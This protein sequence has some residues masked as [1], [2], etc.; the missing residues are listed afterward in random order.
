MKNKIIFPIIIFLLFFKIEQS[1]SQANAGIDQE[2]CTNHTFLN[3]NIPASGYTGTWSIISGGCSFANEHSSST[4]VTN[5]L[6]NTTELKWTVTDGTNT[7]SDNVLIINNTATN[8]VV[9][10]DDEICNNYYTLNANIFDSGESGLWSVVAGTG[11]FANNANNVTDV[12]GLS[13][14][15]NKF[16]WRITKGICHSEDTITI[17]N[18]K[19]T[20]TCEADKTI[21]EDFT[22]ISANNPTYGSGT[23]SVI[24][25]SG[26]PTISNINVNN[27]SVTNLGADTNNLKWTVVNGSCSA[28]DNLIIT[29]DKPTTAIAG[30][31]KT[32][33]T[34]STNLSANN[35]TQGTGTW[36]VVSGNGTF[37][38]PN[39]Y[40]TQVNLINVGLNIYKWKIVKNLCSSED[41]VEI[42]FDY[43]EADAGADDET[44]LNTY[45]LSAN[46]LSG[47]TG[48]WRVTGGSGTF[49]NANQNN[50]E[51][52]NIGN[53]ANTYEWELTRGT[54]VHTDYVTIT[55]NTP[56]TAIAGEDKETCNGTTTL[57]ASLPAIGTGS[58]SLI[59][60]T[61][62]FANSLQTN[63]AVS[64]VGLGNNT[65]R[66]TVSYATCS[67]YDDVIATNNYVTTNAGTDQIVCGTDANLSA[68]TLQ[69]GETG[70]WEVLEGGSN[71]LNLNSPNSDVE[72][73]AI[74]I[75]RFK[76]KITKGI[77]TASDNVE[78]TNNKYYAS[79]TVSGPSDICDDYTSIFGNMPPA[80]VNSFWQVQIGTGIIDDTNDNSTIVNNLSLGENI[81]RWTVEK[82]DCINYDEITINRNTVFAYAGNDFN[83]CE[84]NA[85]LNATPANV[86]ENGEWSV[87]S[88][89][90]NIENATL[91][92]TEVTN[93][94][95]GTNTFTWTISNGTCNAEDNIVITNNKFYTSAGA[96]QQLCQDYANLSASN[97]GTGYWE[98]FYGSGTFSDISNN[99]TT[100]SNIPSNSTNTYRWHAFLNGCTDTDDVNITNNIVIANAGTD[101]SVCNNSAILNA[102]I[103]EAGSGVWTNQSG[104]G[105]FANANSNSTQVTGLSNGINTFRWTVNHL[106]CET[107]D[108]VSV[109]NN[110][111]SVSAGADQEICDD[112]T[113]LSG[114]QPP[115]GETGEWNIVTGF[116]VFENSNLYNTN[117]TNIQQGTNVLSW[118][119]N[120]SGCS[121]NVGEVYITNKGFTAD[122]GANQVLDDFVTVTNLNAVL[123][124]D[125]T[126]YWT[127]VGGYGTIVDETNPNTEV[128]NMQTGINQFSWTVT[129]NGCTEEDVVNITVVNFTPNAGIDRII[130]TNEVRLSAADAGGTPQFW[131]VISGSGTFDNSNSYNTWVRNVGIGT[132]IFRWTVNRNGAIAYDE[133]TVTRIFA[134]AGEDQNVTVNHAILNG[135][136]PP[137]N[138]VGQWSKLSGGGTIMSPTLFN[139]EVTNLSSNNNIFEWTI[140]SNECILSDFVTIFYEASSISEIS[141][142]FKI[143]P[144][145]SN[146]LFTIKNEDSSEYNISIFNI[147]GKN[148]YSEEKINENI[149]NFDISNFKNGIYF[150]KIIKNNKENVIKIIKE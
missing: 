59:S 146:G 71:V 115:V 132:N 147:L 134:E 89:F 121:S 25:S 102:E 117:I 55:R 15:I 77:C 44:C 140:S 138:C 85:T 30:N 92:S 150:L 23:W 86:G 32:I 28:Y 103:P 65:Y 100:V 68:N 9:A 29:N 94:N 76:W 1:F 130:C 45:T 49:S 125:A 133:M 81:I 80:T 7:S 143:Y 3:A 33:C 27:T 12:T 82:D 26:S 67:N 129:K 84:S 111:V 37:S 126:A 118:T 101:F 120:N 6:A 90:G 43:F 149:H 36:S 145:P 105:I 123:P 122:A 112:F 14:G 109:E 104:A 4:E 114:G 35:P 74:G 56:S 75:N 63:T 66:W 53:G 95:L 144:N 131:T 97:V 2:I 72:N 98:V 22:T 17:T 61:G 62:F 139:S 78:I 16:E 83:V 64:N 58:W 42:T 137:E 10:G 5:L 135:N 110:Y 11:T 13:L 70:L 69:A 48:Q 8:S 91:Y 60:G 39:N 38:Y 52:T 107:F 127:L 96:N 99:N 51:V 41:E 50:T 136:I 119:I 106:T 31:D 128:N 148:I 46:S 116:V 88:G 54:C 73:L 113:Q 40:N 124:A 108:D 79:A 141:G 34:N 142:K 18:N 87:T 21:C 93:L 47:A 24:A 19:V 20:A 57:S